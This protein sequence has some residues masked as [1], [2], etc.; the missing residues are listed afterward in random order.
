[1]AIKDKNGDLHDPKNGQYVCKAISD[2]IKADSLNP[3][4]G[5]P[6]RYIKAV[7]GRLPEGTLT[8]QEW[9]QWYESIYHIR[10]GFYVPQGRDGFLIQI[11][12]KVVVT[13]GTFEKPKAV[14]CLVFN[15]SEIADL[16]IALTKEN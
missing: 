4:F 2:Q 8:K 3:I 12:N 14:Y 16:F 10:A 5:E 9:A 15:N 7:R 6:M 1:M 11:G 13:K